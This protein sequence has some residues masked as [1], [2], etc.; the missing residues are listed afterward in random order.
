MVIM[1]SEAL[2]PDNK[3]NDGFKWQTVGAKKM[4]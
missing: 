2:K 4:T 3:V 1:V